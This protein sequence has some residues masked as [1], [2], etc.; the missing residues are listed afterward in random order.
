MLNPFPMSRRKFT[1]LA[2]IASVRRI[3]MS[4][5]KRIDKGELLKIIGVIDKM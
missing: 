5:D 4:V 3:S 1:R 2:V